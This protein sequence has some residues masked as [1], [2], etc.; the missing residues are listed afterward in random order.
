LF[1]TT[2]TSATAASATAATACTTL[3][4]FTFGCAVSRRYATPYRRDLFQLFAFHRTRLRRLLWLALWGFSGL[5]TRFALWA[6][7]TLLSGAASA[8]VVACAV[9][10]QRTVD[11]VRVVGVRHAAVAAAWRHRHYHRHDGAVPDLHA[12]HGVRCFPVH[13]VGVRPG[14]DAL[15]VPALRSWEH[16]TARRR[17]G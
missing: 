14:Q 1:A 13:A 7:G 6:F 3:L 12:V 9:G 5:W 15:C 10:L 17:D 2:G 8:A 4:A 11:A 16:R